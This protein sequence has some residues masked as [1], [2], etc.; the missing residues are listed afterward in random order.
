MTSDTELAAAAESLPEPEPVDEDL[1]ASDPIATGNRFT[2]QFDRLVHR[3]IFGVNA[4]VLL[5]VLVPLVFGYYARLHYSAYAFPPDSR[6]YVTMAL[7]DLGFSDADALRK[8]FAN[9]GTIAESWYFAHSDPTWLMVQSR[10][11]Y[12][13]LAAPFVAVFGI[14][15]GM[16]IAAMV[17]FAVMLWAVTR[18]VQ[19]LYGP[20]AALAAGA[21]LGACGFMMTLAEA[22][23]DPVAIAVLA[24]I[25]LN[26]PLGRRARPH[27][28]V[29][30]ALLSVLLELSR[31]VMPTAAGLAFFGWAWAVAFPG[32]G[33]SRRWRNDWLWPSAIVVGTTVFVH[34]LEGRFAGSGTGSQMSQVSADPGQVAW[35]ITRVDV[36]G[37][38]QGDKALSALLAGALVFV[39]IRFTDVVS[40]VLLGA[41]AGT[42]LV[43][44]AG[45]SPSH[46]RY[47][48]IMFPVAGLAVG[49]LFHRL[50]PAA[51][52]GG[53]VGDGMLRSDRVPAVD[54]WWQR[55]PRRVPV[56]GVSSVVF[57]AVLVGWSATHGSASMAGAVPTAPSAAA[58]LAGDPHAD[59]PDRVV[60]AEDILA[61]EFTQAE[62]LIKG[63]NSSVFLVYADWRHPMRYRPLTSS[64][65]EW[66]HRG[67]D[68]TVVMYPG[69]LSS[70]DWVGLARSF[71]YD[72]T[73]DP[74]TVKVTS[75]VTS[76]YG[77]DVTFTVTAGTGAAR[78]VHQGHATVLYPL[79]ARVP[80]IVTEMVFDS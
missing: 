69:D 6:Y 64:D 46:M 50:A 41:I 11:L 42:Y 39:L 9:S 48:A 57:L 15:E 58:A 75:R 45:V 74:S 5:I 59:L 76:R 19:R 52:R 35:T 54:T 66:G 38:L 25:L 65:P 70:W 3:D 24:L 16:P 7:R 63:N 56:L 78:G 23:T 32:R 55:G 14:T 26:L 18:L 4:A 27:N 29:L 22:V 1:A 67:T 8:Q 10:M 60:P 44:L 43:M 61:G 51:L 37:M 21:V 77:E 2:A 73:L 36:L 71:T 17:A 80:G 33:R 49:A 20:T 47:E 31:Q 30:L 62:E 12:P 72:G 79:R 53:V 68:G 13:F 34:L 40:G 28:L